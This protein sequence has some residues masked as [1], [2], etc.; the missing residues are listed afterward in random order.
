MPGRAATYHR[1]MTE[2]PARA[3]PERE[4]WWRNA[5]LPVGVVVAVGLAA[6]AAI[7]LSNSV[8]GD[9]QPDEAP[10]FVTPARSVF[11]TFD[12]KQR[13]GDTLT[14]TPGSK[15]QG[16]ERTLAITSAT[17]IERLELIAITDV[18][19]GDIIVVVGVP[20]DYKNFA[21][22][23]VVV[24]A[25][26]MAA[27]TAGGFPRTPGGFTGFESTRVLA[28]RPIITARVERVE[29]KTIIARDGAGEVK[30][31]VEPALRL[32]RLRPATASELVEGDRLAGDFTA[33]QPAA[34]L[35][36]PAGTD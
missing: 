32:F 30:L 18:K 10:P 26:E 19:A 6:G 35:S 17:R 27:T 29:G 3:K 7:Y 25:P 15:D 12:I 33:A 20:N 5:L 9:D 22:H 4:K 8:A 14:L 36:R 11:V 24:L 21:I 1:A 2:D 13:E 34:L 23:S 28:D 16:A 31:K